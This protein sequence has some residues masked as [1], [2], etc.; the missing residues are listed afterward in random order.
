M[1]NPI[2]GGLDLYKLRSKHQRTQRLDIRRSEKERERER[3]RERDGFT[4]SPKV[5]LHERRREHVVHGQNYRGHGGRGA[6]EREEKVHHL[7]SFD[8]SLCTI[9]PG[10]SVDALCNA[11]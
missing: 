9:T 2:R 1:C 11:G 6:H 8:S 7:L 10:D 5:S 3:E 4:H